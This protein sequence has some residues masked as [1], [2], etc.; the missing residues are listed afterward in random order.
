MLQ[1][2][3]LSTAIS[4]TF[5]LACLTVSLATA[6]RSAQLSGAGSCFRTDR[7]RQ[8]SWLFVSHGTATKDGPLES[9]ALLKNRAG[10]SVAS[11]S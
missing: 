2:R 10:A 7:Q 1:L 9:L 11:F 3:G 6:S 5:H 4:L 8:F